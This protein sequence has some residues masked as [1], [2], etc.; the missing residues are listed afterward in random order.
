[1]RAA[2]SL[3]QEAQESAPDTKKI[4]ST[5]PVTDRVTVTQL[6]AMIDAALKTELPAKLSV[7][8]EVSGFHDRTHWYFSLKD[9]GAV[10]DC[11]M[12]AS[13]ARRTGS[14]T[15]RDGEEVVARGRV[16]YYARQGRTQL[17]VDRIEPV[18]AGALEQ[19][20]REL[21]QELKGL[22]WFDPE[23]KKPLPRFPRCVAVVTSKTGAA[24]QDVVD[25]F[26]RRARFVDLLIV[27][28]R[29]QGD[30]AA[31]QI[32]GAIAR[33]ARLSREKR[34]IDAIILTRGGGS[35]EDLWAFNERAVARA[36][37]E[38]PLPIVAAVGHETDTTVAEL[39]ADERA[40][41]PTQ[42]AMR[43]SPDAGA[44]LEQTEQLQ[45]RLT[46]LLRHRALRDRQRLRA[47]ASHPL[48]ADPRSIL[49][50]TSSRL[51]ASHTAMRVASRQQIASQRLR[52]SSLT[53]RLTRQRP[54]VVLAL[55]KAR[56]CE[57]RRWLGAASTGLIQRKNAYVHE[58]ARTLNATGPMNVLRRGYSV[59]IR[60]DGRLIRSISDARRGDVIQTR[61]ADGSF[62]STVGDYTEKGS[63]N[64]SGESPDQDADNPPDLF[65]SE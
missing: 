41:T 7:V 50:N 6:A 47:T 55:R 63:G 8:G 35:M 10:V 27:D 39:V 37:H 22:G 13:A 15:P 42:A 31:P 21:C 65:K 5:P 3:F 36:I 9:A 23:K 32:A 64:S 58:L 4:K 43:L 12:F 54:A 61:L 33:I 45:A 19:K 34:R 28:V 17:Y 24:L 49:R 48:V 38:C 46:S 20:L 29:V 44:L 60:A 57:L 26:R 56:I 11:V 16:E 52:L 59:T 14:Y 40:A 2:A 25:T 1:M 62:H 18:G 51:E 30:R 53:T